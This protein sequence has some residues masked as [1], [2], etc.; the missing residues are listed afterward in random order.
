[1]K[2]DPHCPS[3][4]GAGFI[5]D[6]D[7]LKPAVPCGCAAIA[8]ADLGIPDRY[9]SATLDGFWDWWKDRHPRATV[10]MNLGEAQEL[11]GHPAGREALPP[12]LRMKLDHIV[13]KCRPQDGE[14]S[15]ETTWKTIRPAQEPVGYNAFSMWVRQGGG[16]LG[17]DWCWWISG[18]PG[19]G[20]STLAA[21]TLQSICRSAGKAG[22]F[23]S[24][25]N[26]GQQLLNVYHDTQSYR[27]RD[28]HSEQDL[29]GPLMEARVLVLDDL[30]R[31]VSDTRVLRSISQLL[32]H[33]FAKKLPTIFTGHTRVNPTVLTNTPIEKLLEGQDRD[34]MMR[35]LLEDRSTLDRLSRAKSVE[36][37][38]SLARLL[39]SRF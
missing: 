27:N 1:M 28:F 38:P 20:K 39:D 4:R 13:H 7:P 26:F 12:E 3:C 36:L 2:A 8:C 15:A 30:D 37:R 14:S 31:I 16:D 24:I 6:P 29:I 22:K 10:L 35:L 5:L 19:S 32:D 23:I 34:P 18:D 25:R 17:D 9:A 33:R 21:A 11:L